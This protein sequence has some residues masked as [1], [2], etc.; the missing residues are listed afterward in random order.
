MK[1]LLLRNKKE[2]IKYFIG[3][4]ITIIPNLLITFTISYSFGM[5]TATTKEGMIRIGLTSFVI[6]MTQPLIYIFSRALRIGFSRDILLDVRKESFKKISDLSVQEFGQSSKETYLS[7][8]IS[9]FNLF[10]RDFFLSILNMISSGGTFVGG[11]LILWFFVSPVIA[12]STVTITVVLYLISRIFESPVRKT[13]QENQDANVD[14]NMELSNILNGLEIM[15]LYQVEHAFKKIV[16]ATI[17]K[18]ENIKN[19]YRVLNGTQTALAQGIAS[20]YQVIVLVYATYIWTIGK[21]EMTALVLV[22]NLMGRLVWSFIEVTS[23]LNRYKASIDVYNRLTNRTSTIKKG[24]EKLDAFQFLIVKGLNYAY[25][26]HQVFNNLNFSFEKGSKTLIYGPS[27]IGKTTLLNCITQTYSDY[28]GLVQ[29]NG[30]DLREIDPDSFMEKIGYIRQ[31]H[32]MFDESIRYNI[33]L[34]EH[35]DE[36]KLIQVLKDVD[37]WSWVQSMEDGLDHQLKSNGSNVSGGQKQRLSIAREL[38]HDCEVLFVDEPSAS[39]DDETS[40]HIYDT[41][42]SLNR[43][44]VCVS[45]RHLDYLKTRFS[46]IIDLGNTQQ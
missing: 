18:L 5:L 14:Y 44:I 1:Q 22:F 16:R 28:T 43:T 17:R 7:E 39:L 12:L 8:M 46:H 11:I 29:V 30:F 33:T 3:A 36:L 2:M 25:G 21:I 37:L 41:L 45:H 15:K 20:T 6:L 35:Y 27:G 9:D 24:I 19:H 40:K 42:L 4:F 34:N 38:Y 23:Y 26:D 32:F 31:N 13:L 10:E